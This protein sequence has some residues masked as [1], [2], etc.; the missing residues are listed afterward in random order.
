MAHI[1]PELCIKPLNQAVFRLLD[2]L[3][4][5]ANFFELLDILVTIP[6]QCQALG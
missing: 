3:N 2:S 6:D 5:P 1:N 4:L